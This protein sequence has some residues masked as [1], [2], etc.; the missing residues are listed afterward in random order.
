[1]AVVSLVHLASVE[2]PYTML[3][4]HFQDLLYSC[5]ASQAISR[6]SGELLPL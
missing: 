3:I 2:P 5:Q 4:Q 1:M 6:G